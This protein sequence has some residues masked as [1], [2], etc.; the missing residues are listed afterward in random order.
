MFHNFLLYDKIYTEDAIKLDAN[1]V[2]VIYKRLPNENVERRV[3]EGPAVVVPE[4]VEWLALCDS[5][6]LWL[7][8]GMFC[9]IGDIHK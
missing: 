1:H 7:Y 8:R 3:V 6:L 5:I 4:A 9:I 2:I